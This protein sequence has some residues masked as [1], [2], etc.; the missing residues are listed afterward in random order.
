MPRKPFRKSTH[1]LLMN[2]TMLLAGTVP[3]AHFFPAYGQGI[4]TGVIVGR[5]EDASGAIVPSMNVTAT[6][7]A[8]GVKLTTTT[9]QKGEFSFRNVP[10]G[11]YS[12]TVGGAGFAENKVENVNVAAGQDTNL[13]AVKLGVG[14]SS[15]SVQVNTSV[16]QLLQTTESQVSTTF[17]S[18]QTQ[19]LP[20]NGALDNIALF[21]P[22]VA[23]GHDASFSNSNGNNLSI[24]GNRTRSNNYEI[25]GQSNNDNSVG[26]P[27]IFFANQDAVQEIQVI[28]SN[29]SAEYGRNTGG[30]VN[31]VTKSGTNR[32]HGS[33]YEFYTT[34]FFTSQTQ[35]QKLSSA[36]TPHYVDNR[37]GGTLGGP[38][39]RDKV[40]FFGGT[41]WQHTREGFSPF[42]VTNPTPTQNGLSQL[43]A[44]FSGNPA[45]AALSTQ[46]PYAVLAQ[47]HPIGAT[48][49]RQITGPNG[50][51]VPVEFSQISTSVAPLY[52]DQED[53]GRLD[54][55]P[56][57]Q[58]HFYLRYIYQD[59]NTIGNFLANGYTYDVPGTTHSIGGDWSHTFSPNWVNQIHYGFQQSKLFFQG[60]T[61]AN[62]ASMTLSACVSSVAITG[63]GGFGYATNLPQG[64][65]VKVTQAQDNANW[66]HGKHSVSFG[67]D[68]TYQNSPNTFLPDY[69]GGYRFS[70]FSSFVQGVGQLSLGNGNPLIPFTEPDFG[71]YV[72]D[73]WKVLP[74]LTLNLGFRYEFYKQAVNLL[75]DE[76][77]ARE[78]GPNGFWDPTLPLAARTY[79]YTN[80]N[81]KNLQPRIGFAFNPVNIPKLVVRGGYAIQYD[82]AFYNIFLNSA[83]AAPVIN[84]GTFACGGTSPNCIPGGGVSGAN[85]R[86][87]NLPRIPTGLGVNP[88]SRN[89]TNNP[90]TFVNP[91][92]ETYSLGFQYQLQ[93][94]VIGIGYVGNHVARQFQ[95]V[96]ANPYLMPVAMAFPNVIS[97][98]SLCQTPNAIGVGRLSCDNA[99]VRT[100]NNNAFSI[101][102][103]IQVQLQTRSY[104]GATLNASYTYSRTIDN[105][106]EIF[107]SSSPAG[108]TS[109]PEFAQNPLQTDVPE[110]GVANISYPNLAS[111]GL[112]YE[113]PFYK[114]QSGFLGKMLGGYQFTSAWAY[115][116][117]EPWTPQQFYQAT[118]FTDPT[119]NATLNTTSF[120]DTPF[121]QA[122]IGADSCRPVVV[123]AGA[124]ISSVG[125]YVVDPM[126]AFTTNRTGYYNYQSV[127][128]TGKLNA[129][130]AAN[131]AHWLYN[132]Q[133]YATLVGNPFPGS[134]RNT[135]RGQSFDNVDAAFIKTTNIKEGIAV[136]LYFNAFNVLNHPF[137]GTPDTSIEDS[138]YGTFQ[139]SSGNYNNGTVPASRY[140]QLGGKLVF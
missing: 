34:D 42:I 70:N 119:A 5:A 37:Y 48:T 129:P 76:T 51:T 58:D 137:Y 93:G 74:S 23:I 8:T 15:T 100:R 19:D 32:L 115:N 106:D 133:A 131:G 18:L 63:A 46:G 87:L 24:N 49:T 102:N 97:P 89:Y 26:G 88:N 81:K 47:V 3:A 39:L 45:I 83:T 54:W 17:D 11:T 128:G 10:A 69:N 12:V 9:D 67:G 130:I 55:Q 13:E 14:S 135:V 7:G 41:N 111:I 134:P 118:T 114:S 77:V 140:V 138:S 16:T 73:D 95:S 57:S 79:G 85:V 105:V 22:G 20:L 61:Q 1:T 92:V 53:I 44:A 68:F 107:G 139:N 75:H 132:N 103:S 127:D 84:L 36:A 98:S 112:N 96:D 99:N 123:N 6:R 66:T 27:Q 29:F 56:R 62:C 82:P 104:H 72:Q 21:T 52:N 90:S 124:P 33:G 120:C 71:L 136:K 101:Y 122:F 86:A 2:A 110:R 65:V 78:S 43:A 109:S 31:Y 28:T 126:G 25:D 59:T 40:W 64:R 94:A 108:T 121:N 35:G 38:V 30:V 113:L 4:T 91:R 117:G 50:V 125:I 116:G 80:Q 60:G